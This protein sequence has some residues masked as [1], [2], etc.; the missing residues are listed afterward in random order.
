MLCY[1]IIKIKEEV[2]E[3]KIKKITWVKNEGFKIIERE[4]NE[5]ELR[6]FENF[7]NECY[8]IQE[9]LELETYKGLQNDYK[10]D[11][12]ILRES[13]SLQPSISEYEAFKYIVE[14]KT[15]E[16]SSSPY[17]ASYYDS[18]N[19]GWG[20][21]PEGSLRVSDHWNFGAD[22]EHCPTAEPVDGWAVCKYKDGIYHLIQKF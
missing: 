8:F 14:N 10:K 5:V 3:M 4:L 1:T 12:K 6:A 19:I 9:S 17:S 11:L 22:G 7:G 15:S 2:K 20:Y 18:K 16:W 13:G 21:K